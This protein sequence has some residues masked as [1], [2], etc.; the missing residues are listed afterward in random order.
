MTA[1][2]VWNGPAGLAFLHAH[3]HIHKAELVV[4]DDSDGMLHSGFMA[5]G[6]LHNDEDAFTHARSTPAAC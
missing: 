4:L 2:Q 6:S 1:M 3:R 5:E